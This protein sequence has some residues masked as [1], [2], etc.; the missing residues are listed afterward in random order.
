[1]NAFPLTFTCLTFW[2]ICLFHT[3]HLIIVL[4][5]N[6]PGVPAVV[7]HRTHLAF[8]SFKDPTVLKVSKCTKAKCFLLAFHIYQMEYQRDVCRRL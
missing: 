5:L 2:K 4:V 7:L 8:C 3:D 6:C 1:M